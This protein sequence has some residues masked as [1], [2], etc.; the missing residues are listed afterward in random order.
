[1]STRRVF[2]LNSLL[3]EVISEVLRKDLHHV[4]KKTEMLTI[5]AV[6]ITADLSF[7]KVFFSLIGDL[8]TKEVAC[9]ELNG[10]AGQIAHVASRKVRMRTFPKL[11][12]YIDEGLEKQLRICEILAKVAPP[13]VEP[14]PEGALGEAL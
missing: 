12:F 6:E 3:K 8:K 11:R 7:A 4:A 9:A 2:R 10:I 13:P 14:P 1:M 5:T